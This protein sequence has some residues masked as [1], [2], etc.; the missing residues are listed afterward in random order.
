MTADLALEPAFD[1]GYVRNVIE[2][3]VGKEQKLWIGIARDQP[4]AS[5]VGGVEENPSLR[6]VDQIAICLEDAAAKTLVDHRIF[7]VAGGGDP[8]QLPVLRLKR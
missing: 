1:F 2:M 3:A 8:G 6:G 5:S 4:I 7:T